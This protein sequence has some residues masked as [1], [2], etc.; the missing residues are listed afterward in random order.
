MLGSSPRR[1]ARDAAYIGL[2]VALLA[3]CAWIAVPV[4]VGTPITLQTM[5]LCATVGLL[6]GRRGTI[7]VGI[8]LLMGA[9]GLP[10]FA[11]F[12]AG[13]GVLVGV[14]GG[15][16][17]GMLPAA[18]VMGGVLFVL[19]RRTATGR[20]SFGGYM[21]SFVLGVVTCYLAGTA[22]FIMLYAPET[23]ADGAVA[24]ILSCTVPYL[25]P[26]ALKCLL[27]ARLCRTLRG[28]VA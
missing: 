20:I 13:A 23:G 17:W 19:S 27:A 2:S 8:Y 28:R 10:V 15:Y 14:T 22:W 18:A 25:A 4:S 12:G 9:L 16:L 7:A 11:G 6:G 21:A 5:G 3:V 1:S 26:D 24:A